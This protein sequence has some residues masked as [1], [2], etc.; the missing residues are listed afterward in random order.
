V[1]TIGAVVRPAADLNPW[2]VVTMTLAW[3]AVLA[4]A[5]V[6]RDGTVAP[7]VRED[8]EHVETIVRPP[9]QSH[10]PSNPSTAVID[11][12]RELHAT[13]ESDRLR[14]LLARRLPAL[15]G[16]RDVWVVAR[17][18]NRQHIIVP[19]VGGSDAIAMVGDEPRQ[20]STYPMKADGRTVGVLGAAL[21]ARGFTEQEHRQF[22]LVTS[23]VAQSLATATAFEAMREASLVDALT[24]CAM[25]AEGER[26][27]EAELRRAQRA[28]TS[29]AVLMLDLDHFK[30][31]NDRFGHKT[32]D[33]ALTAVGE[34]LLTTLRASD[35]RCRWGGE[36]FLLVLPDSSVDRAQ[37]A[38]DNIRHR[39]ANTPV[40]AGDQIVHVTA[41]IGVTLSE[42]GETDVQQLIMRADTGLYEA[43]RLGRNL[44]SLILAPSAARQAGARAPRPAP[45]EHAVPHDG[46]WTR[47]EPPEAAW[48]GVERRDARRGDRRQ[49]P[50][51]GRRSTDALLAASWNAR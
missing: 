8:R 29:V 4:S 6:A 15:L 32:G 12:A 37:R 50:S 13:L 46:P 25:R 36:E 35:V 16:V 31:I 34:T 33:A 5:L 39:I 21:S 24:G 7:P 2:Q 22:K 44:V 28:G 49:V 51:P 48:D 1:L 23:L 18:G 30:R 45:P 14:L 42:R 19:S 47:M 41:S 40:A 9:A 11:F 38:A 43:K 20:W 26:R 10:Q 3:V 17:F 27:M